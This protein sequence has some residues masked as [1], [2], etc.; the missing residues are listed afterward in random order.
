MPDAPGILARGPWAPEAIEASWLQEEFQPPTA[1]TQAADVAL[2]ALRARGSP[3]HDGLA[4]RLVNFKTGPGRLSLELQP[5]RWA[6]RLLPLDG[7][8]SLSVLCVVRAA[9]GSWLAGR[10][11]QWLASWAGR[12]ALG[13]G[14]A[15]EVQENPAGSM[16]RELREEWSVDPQRLSVEALVLLPS[17][18]VLLV[19]QAWLAEGASVSPDHEHDAY[20]W[21]PAEID[22]WPDEADEPLR[23]MAALLGGR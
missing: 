11:A 8:R 18:M 19:G 22:R 20:A 17:E 6:L 23:R 9:D 13:A 16:Q 7:A 10:R 1:D 12:W 14:G 5:A 3:S 21:W 4:A 15:V 2:E